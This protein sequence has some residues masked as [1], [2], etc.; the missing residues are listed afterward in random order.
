MFS[1][2]SPLSLMSSLTENVLNRIYPEI[3]TTLTWTC[4]S[5]LFL[6][7]FA[8]CA[9][10]MNSYHHWCWVVW[11]QTSL[12]VKFSSTMPDSCVLSFFPCNVLIPRDDAFYHQPCHLFL[13]HILDVSFKEC[14]VIYSG[15]SWSRCS[16]KYFTSCKWHVRVEWLHFSPWSHAIRHNI[17]EIYYAST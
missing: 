6:C 5:G 14:Y 2:T 16:S 7:I 11:T 9:R 3:S 4:K 17:L 13:A 15:R 10:W 12:Q 8:G 1:H